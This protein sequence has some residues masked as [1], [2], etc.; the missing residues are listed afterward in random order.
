MSNMQ[1]SISCKAQ[2]GSAI[3]VS[4]S[5]FGFA[6]GSVDIPSNPTCNSGT[7]THAFPTGTNLT[8]TANPNTGSYV[9]WIGCDSVSRNKCNKRLFFSGINSVTA[10][11]LTK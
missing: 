3:S 7:C 1:R 2:F 10:N 6:G 4:I 5:N 9:S 8:L 11:F